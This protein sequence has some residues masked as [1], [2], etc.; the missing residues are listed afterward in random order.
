MRPFINFVS[1]DGFSAT[2]GA[3]SDAAPEEEEVTEEGKE[4]GMGGGTS[5]FY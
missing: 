4:A 5:H 3:D 1:Y 2:G